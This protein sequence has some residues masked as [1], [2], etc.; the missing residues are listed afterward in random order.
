[1]FFV[2]C[3]FVLR[4]VWYAVCGMC[5]V[6]CVLCI[7][8]GMVCAVCYGMR[9]VCSSELSTVE[10]YFFRI[11]VNY[12]VGKLSRK[13]IHGLNTKKILWEQNNPT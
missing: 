11:K 8:W 7:V 12:I 5:R 3:F 9:V 1:M 4:G 13:R 2:L 6:C 10:S